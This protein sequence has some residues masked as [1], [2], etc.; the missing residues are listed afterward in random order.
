MCLVV[1]YL[2]ISK[3]HYIPY[4][5]KWG[6]A[7]VR[8]GVSCD[9]ERGGAGG[10]DGAR[11][12]AGGGGGARRRLS[13]RGCVNVVEHFLQLALRGAAAARSVS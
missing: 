11:G 1:I 5:F 6:R 7:C 8:A 4:G 13:G 12:G 10:C 9:R 3:R 2:S